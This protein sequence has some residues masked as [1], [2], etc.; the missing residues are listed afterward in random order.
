[1]ISSIMFQIYFSCA[2]TQSAVMSNGAFQKHNIASKSNVYKVIQRNSICNLFTQSCTFS[3]SAK[4]H[5]AHFKSF[6]TVF[7]RTLEIEI[8]FVSTV[9]HI[10][11]SIAFFSERLA[12]AITIV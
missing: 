6:T 11:M 10:I 3:F 9:I 1:M 7:G 5:V 12:M 8:Y 4:L 2:F